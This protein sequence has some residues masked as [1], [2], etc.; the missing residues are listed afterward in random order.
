MT[1]KMN[2]LKSLLR[3]EFVIMV[4]FVVMLKYET[5]VIS[6]KKYRCFADS[7]CSIKVKLNDKSS[8]VFCNMNNYGPYLIMKK[9][10]QIH[11][12]TKCY[13]LNVD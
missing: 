3:D 11:F 4:M 9:S 6:L 10:T 13:I 1:K 8:I 5:I 7:Y 12:Q 2:I